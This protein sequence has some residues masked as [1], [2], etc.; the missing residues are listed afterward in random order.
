MPNNPVQVVLRPEQYM[1]RPDGGGG[2]AAKDFFDGR[3]A[4]FARH[5]DRLLKEVGA[6]QDKLKTVKG[7]DVAYVKV[8]LQSAALAKSH[9]PLQ[10]LFKPNE[11]PLVG[12]GSLGEMYFEVTLK[13][14]QSAAAG[15]VKAETE[16]TRRNSHDELVATSARSEVGAIETISMPSASDKRR[17]DE[18]A[19]VYQFAE[20][21]SARYLAIELFIDEAGFGEERALRPEAR[22]ALKKFRAKLSEFAPGLS[23]WTSG[24]EWKT[25]HLTVLKFSD[26]L[27]TS[28]R[29]PKVLGSVLSFLDDSP[30]VRQISLGPVVR[31]AATARP[32]ATAA[33]LKALPVPRSGTRY[34]VVGIVDGG[35]STHPSIAAWSAGT[36]GFMNQK[37]A[38]REH[39]TFIAGL[40][41]N[42]EG[43]NPGQP[44]ESE[45]CKYFDF[46]LFSAD[47]EMFK[48]NYPQGF[49]DMMGQ[50]D[51]ELRDNKPEGLRVINVSLTPQ[52]LTDPS[53][54]GWTAA[55][56][57]ELAD[58]HD[59]IFVI[60]A[61]N[62]EGQFVRPRWP[63]DPTRALQLV[64]SYPYQ[65]DD[66][67][68]EPGE[69]ARNLTVGALELFSAGA[70]RPARYTRRGPATSA[71][72]KPD[73]AHIGGCVV[74]GQPLT[75]LAPGGG[76]T[77]WDGTSFSAPMVAKTLA[78]LNHQISGEQPREVLL[79]L[80][81]HFAQMPKVLDHKNLKSVS[82]DFAG[83][84]MP[85]MNS[86]MLSTD[87]HAITLI[88]TDYLPEQMEMSFDFDWP[89]RLIVNGKTRG[90]VTLSI[91]YSP[92]LESEH[93][94]EFA[95]VNL[96]AYLRQEIVD[97][98]T[99][100]VSYKGRLTQEQAGH[101][102]RTLI[103]HGAKWWPV[104]HYGRSFKS[105]SGSSR[106]RLVVDSLTRAGTPFPRQGVRFAVVLTIADPDG[107]APVFASMRQALI[108]A[109]VGI[110][111]IRTV[112]R[113][114]AR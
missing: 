31:H 54:Y 6:I 64:A 36:T 24:Q 71:G 13:S 49:I 88:F 19:A 114:R 5:K 32:T 58:R 97:E 105:L 80:M 85:A 110:Q 93:K 20:H 2:G 100:E 101:L 21:P 28:T 102:E 77:Q 27:A 106:W 66:R 37:E 52:K 8:K 111:D 33:Q 41:V 9:R 109:G 69:S 70:T 48:T 67:V 46:D 12:T 34:P 17:F 51:T 7:T 72:I 81:Y 84:G 15:I 56:L 10:V 103:M 82:K 59:V 98:E 3:N 75:S 40:L 14:L 99:G 57:D 104:K 44:L 39:G 107:T 26:E 29:L 112:T 30:L 1:K 83:F 79:A 35:V 96:D 22:T 65:G 76:T 43:F 68:Y 92:P 63:G 60:S 16:L 89:A 53:S 73:F 23:V 94:S 38:D 108:T 47:E 90:K 61:G 113:V 91:V 55:M 42:G 78:L 4:E 87:D 11:F 95:R 74:T 86:E 50:L 62:L 25:V 18:R 45:P